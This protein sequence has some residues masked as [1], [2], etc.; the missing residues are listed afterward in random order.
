VATLQCNVVSAKETIYSGE[1]SMLIATGVEGEVG[2]LPGHIPF[3]TLLKPG[4]MQIKTSNGNDEMVYV[5][6]GVLEVQ[7]H[8]VTVLADTAV[9]AHDLDE[10]KILEARRHAE[11]SLQNQ[12]ADIDT[13]AALAA[14][15]E[16]L[17]QLQTLQKFKNRA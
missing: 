10:A 1:I 8:L 17:A 7:P 16:S 5:S 9:R 15:A 12:K 14:L 2:I 11:Q 4:T 13:S 3:I 6:G